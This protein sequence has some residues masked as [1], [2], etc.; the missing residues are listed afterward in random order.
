MHAFDGGIDEIRDI[1]EQKQMEWTGAQ[2]RSSVVKRRAEARGAIP[3]WLEIESW[4]YTFTPDVRYGA[5]PLYQ[6]F[7]L[8]RPHLFRVTL[9]ALP[10]PE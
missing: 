8:H 9:P 10:L 1:Q 7:Q 2:N 4:S 6:A 3:V 5:E